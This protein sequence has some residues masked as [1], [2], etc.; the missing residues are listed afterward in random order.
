MLASEKVYREKEQELQNKLNEVQSKGQKSHE[1]T[2][3]IQRALAES[4]EN[5]KKTNE[6]CGELES[7]IEQ[8][9]NEIINVK[10]NN[11]ELKTHL[12]NTRKKLVGSLSAEKVANSLC[13]ICKQRVIRPAKDMSTY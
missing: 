2:E 12:E 1:V 4:N 11:T 13:D 5:E 3:Q 6:K 7:R 9:K 8:L 10:A